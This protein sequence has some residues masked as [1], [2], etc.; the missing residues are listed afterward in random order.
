[1][2]TAATTTTARARRAAGPLLAGALSLA[3]LAGCSFTSNNVSCSGSQCTA[4]LTGEGS[5]AEILGTSLV[6]AGTQDDRATLSVGSAEVS[7]AEGESVT[8]GPLSLTCTAVTA[9]GVEL[10]A[11]LG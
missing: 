2:T 1:M 4:S 3:A 11:S 10:T 6:F 9:D 8:A 5:E 7:C